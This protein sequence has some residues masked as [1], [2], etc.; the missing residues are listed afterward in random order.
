MVVFLV[1]RATVV[2][3]KYSHRLV[4][5]IKLVLSDCL[6]SLTAKL[7]IRLRLQHSQL[8]CRPSQYAT[9]RAPVPV[10]VLEVDITFL[11]KT[12]KVEVNSALLLK[13]E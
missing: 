7:I 12:A 2:G 10:P 8:R 13:S 5:A 11:L 6:V 4:D 1:R 3:A 9:S